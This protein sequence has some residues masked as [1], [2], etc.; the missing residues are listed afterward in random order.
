MVHPGRGGH[1]PTDGGAR[2]LD[3]DHRPALGAEGPAYLG[4]QPAVGDH[5]L[6]P[7]LRRAAAAGWPDRRLRWPQADVHRRPHRVRR[8]FGTRRPGP[9]SG[10]AVRRTCSSGG[11]RRGDGPCSPVPAD[12]HLPVRPEGAGQGLRRLRRGVRRRGSHRRPARRHP[13]PVRLVALVPAGERP[14]RPAGRLL[15]LP[16][17]SRE[18]GVGEHQVRRSWRPLVHGRPGQPGLRVHQGGVGRVELDPHPDLPRH[19]G[20]PAG[21]LRAGRVPVAAIRSCPFG[22]SPSGTGVARIW[23]PS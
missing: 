21:G 6:H 20:G 7:G 5:R 16:C 14:H 9:G 17:R 8:R 23:P 12:H 10:P 22:S 3:R 19:R 15:C 1:R 4:G 2:R 13:H 11:V 18:P